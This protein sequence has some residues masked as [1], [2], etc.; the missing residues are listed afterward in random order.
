MT[1]SPPPPPVACAPLIA[2][3]AAGI[4]RRR[5]PVSGT[6]AHS[7]KAAVGHA[8]GRKLAGAAD[9]VPDSQC[10]P[11]DCILALYGHEWRTGPVSTVMLIRTLR[12]AQPSAHDITPEI[13]PSHQ[14]VRYTRAE[15]SS[16]TSA[17]YTARALHI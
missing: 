16:R 2:E 6:G 11:G 14:F 13:L 3:M 10:P 1:L 7:A 12:A 9:T 8:S 5:L 17:K 4:Q 15:I